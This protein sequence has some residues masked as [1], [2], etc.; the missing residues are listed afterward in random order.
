[1][2][3]VLIIF[4][5]LIFAKMLVLQAKVDRCPTGCEC[6][7]VQIRCTQVIPFTVPPNIEEVILSQTDPAELSPGR[8]C[9][10]DWDNVTKLYIHSV[11]L[12]GDV[13]E[14]HDRTFDCLGQIKEFKLRSVFLH[15][16]ST[17]TF[18]GLT[19][20]NTFDLSGC[21]RISWDDLY[22]TLS[23]G[24]NFPNITSLLLSGVAT[25]QT[26]P[27]NFNQSFMEALAQRPVVHLDLSYTRLSLDFT[28]SEK[29]C[30][31]LTYFDLSGTQF[32]LPPTFLQN[33][34]C[35]ALKTVDFSDSRF[36]RSLIRDLSCLSRTISLN[37]DFIPFFENVQTVYM[38]SIVSSASEIKVSNCTF[39]PNVSISTVH[40]SA[41][42][43]PNVDLELID[44][45][46][47]YL[48]LSNNQ[49][50]NI[51]GRT[52][53]NLSALQTLDL[54][55]NKLATSK[56]TFSVL[57]RHN[58][59]LKILNVSNS[60]MTSLPADTVVSNVKLE[61]FNLSHNFFHE[62][63]VHISH[64]LNLAILDLRSNSIQFLNE[65]SR[66]VLDTLYHTQ[67]ERH[68]S[69]NSTPIIHVLLQDNPFLCNCDQLDF[70]RWFTSSPLFAT[71]RNEYFCVSNGQIVTMDETSVDSAR[72]DCT[73]IKR[74]HLLLI[75]TTTV[76][77]VVVIV[78]VVTILLWYKRHQTAKARQ[79]LAHG[80]RRIRDNARRFPVFLSYSSD[81]SEF[82]RRHIL[83][84]LE[85]STK[86]KK[87]QQQQTT[88]T[89]KKKKKKQTKKK[90]TNSKENMSQL[91][92]LWYLSHRRPAKAQA[93]LHIHA[94]SP[95]PSLFTH[96][97]C[98]SRRKV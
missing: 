44:S 15:S 22:N 37:L 97:K 35:K 24:I 58:Q 64:L 13:F 56:N 21:R 14:L 79:L 33:R 23:L 10:V 69:T 12:V 28:D 82:V 75:L 76:T 19:N 1:M 2:A 88:T 90:Q 52:F 9:Y 31:T 40:F 32:E 4:T 78:M 65:T 57:L 91:M 38:N 49:I 41:N 50:E 85:V 60:Y 87:K 81:E 46:L 47:K 51:N 67:I 26:V 27:L 8:F 66:S 25:R 83:P 54:S 95:E 53:R 73:R 70:T 34:V 59:N 5:Q 18:S 94:F 98:G 63:P 17:R 43:I 84:K 29:L 62:I 3:A 74:R 61:T 80:I 39:I 96:M 16:F 71:S 68:N 7:S 45:R 86:K 72:Q 11:K 77:P 6:F 30:Q 93:S 20:L 92:R 48:D 55:S 89:T 36:F 42:Y